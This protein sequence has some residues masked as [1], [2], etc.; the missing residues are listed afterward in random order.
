[1]DEGIYCVWLSL[2]PRVASIRFLVSIIV[3]LTD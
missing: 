1:M 2:E 3:P